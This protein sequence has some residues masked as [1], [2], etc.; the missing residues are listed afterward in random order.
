MNLLDATVLEVLGEPYEGYGKWWVKVRYECWG[1]EGTCSVMRQTEDEA[2]AV[3][4]GFVF[5]C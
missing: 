3:A 2:R 1:R 4:P 5:Q